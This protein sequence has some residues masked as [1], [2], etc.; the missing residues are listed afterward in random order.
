MDTKQ[1]LSETYNTIYLDEDIE[2][3]MLDFHWP[4]HREEALIKWTAQGRCLLEIGFGRGTV[5]YNLHR[6]F[7][8]LYGVELSSVRLQKAQAAFCR[9]NV[10]N[11]NLLVGNI[12]KG[13]PFNDEQFDCII[14]SDVI[15]HVVDVWAAMEEIRRLLETGGRLITIT[16]NFA[17]LRRRMS[18][19]MGTFPATSAKNEGFNVRDGEFFDGGHMHYFTFSVIEKLYRKYRIQPEKRYGFGTAGRMH[20]IYPSLLSESVFVLGKKE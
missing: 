2:L 16:P 20:N 4:R 14:W 7:E 19:L 1:K 9:A 5:L 15:E 6:Q 3:E 17:K 18:L 8:R 11:V 12:E 13:L 10:H